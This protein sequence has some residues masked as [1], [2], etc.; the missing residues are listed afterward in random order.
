MNF[1][2]LSI[3]VAVL[4]FLASLAWMIFV[5]KHGRG[6]FVTK[7]SLQGKRSKRLDFKLIREIITESLTFAGYIF[8]ALN[9]ILFIITDEWVFG[10]FVAKGTLVTI[11]A[12]TVVN[13]FERLYNFAKDKSEES[14]K[15]RE[16]KEESKN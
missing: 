5:V 3:L 6:F 4:S 13:I 12:F 15:V 14:V 9:F 2:I 7:E 1:D 8:L 10:I 16:V 11:L